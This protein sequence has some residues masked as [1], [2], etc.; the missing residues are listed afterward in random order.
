[1]D[2]DT[3]SQNRDGRVSL[4]GW[5]NLVVLLM[6]WNMMG[7]GEKRNKKKGVEKDKKRGLWCHRVGGRFLRTLK[8]DTPVLERKLTGKGEVRGWGTGTE[9]GAVTLERFQTLRR[10]RRGS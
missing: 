6:Y 10:P 9:G 4:E 3:E 1:V 2:L 5:G 8:G 7:E